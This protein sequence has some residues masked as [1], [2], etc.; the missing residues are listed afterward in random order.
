MA[1]CEALYDSVLARFADRADALAGRARTIAWT[2][3][4][5]RAEVL[6]RTALE[7]HADTPE[8]LIGLAQTLFWKGQPGLA[9]AYAARARALAPQ[10]RTARDLERVV[11]AALR[12][13]VATS[14]DGATDSDQNDFIALEGTVTGSLGTD[15]RGTVRAGWR[16]A[17]DQAGDGS[18]YWAGGHLIAAVGHGAVLRAGLGGRR[19]EPG[20]GGGG[21]PPPPRLAPWG[22]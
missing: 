6:W 12:P 14:V 7:R 16:H 18:S 2:G 3:D 10:D 19:G 20:G 1:A 15:L 11:R 22:A 8:L 17:T 9:E 4:L 13:E 5:D 21:A